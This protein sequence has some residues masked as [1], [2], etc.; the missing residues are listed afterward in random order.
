MRLK[1]ITARMVLANTLLVALVTI[2]FSQIFLFQLKRA[3]LDD[4]NRQGTS[5]T[6]NLALNAELGLLLEDVEALDALG[7]N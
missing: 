2:T 3:L 4:F 5:L 7:Q 1:S 6:E